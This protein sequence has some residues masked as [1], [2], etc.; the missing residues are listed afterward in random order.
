M[1]NKFKNSVSDFLFVAIFSILIFFG[2]F[3][4]FSDFK[5]P[6]VKK[7]VSVRNIEHIVNKKVNKKMRELEEKKFLLESK[8]KSNLDLNRKHFDAEHLVDAEH[9]IDAEHLNTEHLDAN[10]LN[11]KHLDA[12]LQPI[13]MNETR[14][15][16]YSLEIF[17][18]NETEELEPKHQSIYDGIME[19]A[20]L[21]DGNNIK[22]EESVQEYKQ[23]LIKKARQEGWEIELNDDLEVIKQVK[24]K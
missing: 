21:E 11:A 8:I 16:G 13:E 9:L 19:E 22:Q 7:Q 5:K 4:I 18:K 3:F 6:S 20:S 1:P 12:E 17:K 2:A 10:H 15:S 14:D 24:L 23:K